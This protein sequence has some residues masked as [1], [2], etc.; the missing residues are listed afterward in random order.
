MSSNVKVGDVAVDVENGEFSK[1]DMIRLILNK[2]IDDYEAHLLIDRVLTQSV[3]LIKAIVGKPDTVS[4]DPDTVLGQVLAQSAVLI[5]AIIGK[6][7][8]VSEDPDTVLGHALTRSVDL[9]AAIVG[10]P[11]SPVDTTYDK[12][13]TVLAQASALVAA[14]IKESKS[15]PYQND[16]D[17]LPQILENASRLIS[18][19]V[20]PKETWS[21]GEFSFGALSNSDYFKERAGDDVDINEYINKSQNKINTRISGNAIV[22]VPTTGSAHEFWTTGNNP[23][24]IASATVPAHQI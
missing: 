13:D 8:T 15:T 14:I 7:D 6:P 17:D 9:F 16:R 23:P 18:E 2:V 19:I 12:V 3:A 4:E 11:G 24:A 5:E 21:F 20:T 10:K 1:A 22:T